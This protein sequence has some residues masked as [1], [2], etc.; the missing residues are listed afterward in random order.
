VDILFLNRS[1][2]PDVEATGQLLTELCSD[3]AQTHRV[4]VIAGR[5]NFVEASGSGRWL[6]REHHQGVEIIRVGNRRFTKKSFLGRA[7]GLLSYLLLAAWAAFRRPRPDV[8]VVETDPPLLGLLG[9]LL[10]SWHRC[11][12]VFYLQDLFPEVGLALGRL[13]PG[14][15]TRFLYWATQVGLQ[16]ADRIVVLGED[17]RRR[18]HQRGIDPARVVLVP[19]WIDTTAI[20]AVEPGAGLRRVWEL[21]GEFVVMYSGNLGLSQG[22]DEV[23]TVARELRGEPVKFVLVGEGA[24]KAELQARAE[25]WGL[26]NVQFRPYEPKER[27]SASL[28]TADLH[29]IPLRRGLAGCIVPSKLYGILAAGRPYVAAVDDDS[30]VAL[31]TRAE[32]TGLVIA[33]DGSEPLA[34]AIRWCLHHPQEL[35]EMGRRGR[36][37]AEQRFDRRVSVAAFQDVL[38]QVGPRKARERR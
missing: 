11:R 9:A 3:L 5:P 12:L 30:E 25:Q 35:R 7:V 4:T 29:L 6:A 19:N 22:L 10:K 34:A 33:P 17:M 28:G 20:R 8:I 18:V 23:L 38:E 37:V 31:V 2:W 26:R 1:Y 21:N 16:R 13:K 27:L 36:R 14:L 15:L 32:Q 24:A